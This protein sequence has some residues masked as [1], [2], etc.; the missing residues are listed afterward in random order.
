MQSIRSRRHSLPHRLP[1]LC[2]SGV[3]RAIQAQALL[4]G[5]LLAAASLVIGASFAQQT[6]IVDAG[7]VGVP[8][9]HFTQ[10]QPA[11]DAAAPGDRIEVRGSYYYPGFTIDRG[12]SVYAVQNASCSSINVSGVATSDQ[13][14]LYGFANIGGLFVTAC[15]GTVHVQ[16][17]SVSYVA[18]TD[19]AI[20]ITNSDRVY[21]RDV[22]V[23]WLPNFGTW[24]APPAVRL[25]NSDVVFDQCTIIGA[26]GDGLGGTAS[27]ALFVD[28]WSTALVVGGRLQGGWGQGGSYQGPGIGCEGP[29]IAGPAI[30][31]GGR[32]VALAGAEILGG[33]GMPST[34]GCP[35]GIAAPAVTPMATGFGQTLLAYGCIVQPPCTACPTESLAYLSSP[36]QTSIGTTVSIDVQG[37]NADLVGLFA[38][39]NHTAL[40][41]PG[42]DVPWTLSTSPV[43]L[44]AFVLPA[45]GTASY[46]QVVPNQPSLLHLAVYY[47][48]VSWSPANGLDATGPTVLQIR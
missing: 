30:D 8:G 42:F 25:A 38:D 46:S 40:V 35:A 45:N 1:R 27:T 5:R 22:S 12:V 36:S 4:F 11:V 10:V 32:T 34:S 31:G 14:S 13:A 9:V 28:F 37:A 2:R 18:V 41:I 15:A 33:S 7:G 47:Q 3:V 48:G 21:L 19:P 24:W 16:A 17:T 23:A 6:W 44:A 39:L 26:P 20:E 29:G 43:A